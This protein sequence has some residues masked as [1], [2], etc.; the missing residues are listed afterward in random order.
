MPSWCC[1]RHNSEGRESEWTPTPLCQW[2]KP[3]SY[4]NCRILILMLFL[5]PDPLFKY[6]H[7]TGIFNMTMNCPGNFPSCMAHLPSSEWLGAVH[8][9]SVTSR[10]LLYRLVTMD[11]SLRNIML[12]NNNAWGI[13]YIMMFQRVHFTP[14]FRRLDVFI[15]RDYFF[16]F[17]TSSDS[18]D[19]TRGLWVRS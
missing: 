15:L 18:W 17:R 3:L 9:W 6:K 19:Q 12:D 5:L 8:L 16:I 4:D 1:G 2:I 11:N 10:M 13:F 14:A 7:I